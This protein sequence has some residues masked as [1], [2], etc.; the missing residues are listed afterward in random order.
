MQW[1]HRRK[2]NGPWQS[3]ASTPWRRWKA[4]AWTACDASV[5]DRAAAW[6]NRP[7]ATAETGRGL[8]DARHHLGHDRLAQRLHNLGRPRRPERANPGSPEEVEAAI[9]I[10]LFLHLDEGEQGLAR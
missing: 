8:P 4:S 9:R 7:P 3:R 6:N 2:M 10:V 1:R 5:R